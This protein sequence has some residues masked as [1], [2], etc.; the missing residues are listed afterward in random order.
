ML[1]RFK[2]RITLS[3]ICLSFLLIGLMIAVGIQLKPG[4]LIGW[5]IIRTPE[6]LRLHI[7][8]D[9]TVDVDRTGIVFANRDEAL[10]SLDSV[11][12]PQTF[13]ALI[14][15]GRLEELPLP[16]GTERSEVAV[17]LAGDEDRRGVSFRGA[18]RDDQTI[19]IVKEVTLGQY[20]GIFA[21]AAPS[22]T[23]PHQRELEGVV[24]N[25]RYQDMEAES[26]P[27]P[28]DF[29]IEHGQTI[30]RLEQDPSLYYD[31]LVPEDAANAPEEGWPVLVLAQ[32]FGARYAS[33]A[34]DKLGI[35]VKPHFEWISF[36]K[37]RQILDA[38]V[39]EIGADYP[40]DDQR[41]ILHGC[42]VGGQFA[43]EYTLAEPNRVLGAV[44]MAPIHLEVPPQ[45]TWQI[46]FVFFYGDL[47]P[48]YNMET[49]A[50]IESM[51]RKMDSVELYLDVGQAHVCD[52]VLA[53]EAIQA[54]L[55]E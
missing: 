41:L 12:A 55:V 9:W 25:L 45:D 17:A 43:F 1:R 13:R 5:K 53:I 30:R 31:L 32:T 27:S 8:V 15:S 42:S 54:L 40:V 26:S 51:Q 19:L 16:E 4:E 3:L 35:V 34:Q 2:K 39:A 46:P 49:R 47:D 22:R 50:V 7:P 14:I 52:P 10:D 23:F 6:G 36:E 38:I 11:L 29:W 44:V 24:G 33:I 37:D 21:S 18:T 20:A 48:F 28:I